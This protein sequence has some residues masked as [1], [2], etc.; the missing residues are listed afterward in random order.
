M[1]FNFNVWE[2]FVTPPV[3]PISSWSGMNIN[4]L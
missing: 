2:G 1:K 4:G 3:T